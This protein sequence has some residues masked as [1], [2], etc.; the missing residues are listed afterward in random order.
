M[1]VRVPAGSVVTE[2][3]TTTVQP[4][5]ETRRLSDG[6]AIVSKPEFWEWIESTSAEVL[7]KY[8]VIISIYRRALNGRAESLCDQLNYPPDQVIFSRRWIRTS[9]GGGLYKI[10]VKM[11]KQLRFDIELDI[12][13]LPKKAEEIEAA[14]APA[15]QGAGY[16]PGA[17]TT[18]VLRELVGML[19]EE[20]RAARGGDLQTE[21][22]RNSMGLGMEVL[23]QSVPAVGAI[24]AS[25]AAGA[26]GGSSAASALQDRLMAAMIERLLNPAPPPDPFAIFE[27]VSTTL[28]NLSSG[29][30]G[31]G[32]TV[33]DT[34]ARLAPTILDKI[35][36]NLAQVVALREQELR[37]MQV[38][39]GAPPINVSPPP[40]PPSQSNPLPADTQAPAAPQAQAPPP[41]P[42]PG[43]Q[44]FIELGVAR[45]ATNPN[46]SVD[47]AATEML[48]LLDAYVPEL[49]NGTVE[50]PNAESELL[51]M[52]R[53]RPIL[54]QVPQNP[55][56]TEL[57]QKF[58]EKA[59]ESRTPL[60]D[61]PPADPPPYAS[62]G[63]ENQP[64][65]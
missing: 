34:V 54:Q 53:E 63:Q 6:T 24:V 39:G 65:A 45:I 41:A 40:T 25:A 12:E 60:P 26:G 4:T 56:L 16:A 48:V 43:I 22:L 57:I 44:D 2:T 9:F 10:M 17:E 58:L 38:R 20:L 59:R 29:E 13:G 21:A 14:K 42:P 3:K 47:T 33:W 32:G 49:V 28:K 64:S 62:G 31:G 61:A 30:A 52:F 35:G 18:M 15:S 1:S 19:R 55:R 7:A 51:K 23:R 37:L 50:D 27:R 5:S 8:D 36:G 46:L 11:E